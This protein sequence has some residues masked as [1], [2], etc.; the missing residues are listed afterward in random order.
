MTSDYL[1]YVTISTK[2]CN[3]LK[4]VS[5]ESALAEASRTILLVI[6][7]VSS[8]IT[9]VQHHMYIICMHIFYIYNFAFK[10]S[11]I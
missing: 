8:L 3:K 2:I 10:P 9:F 6:Y 11:Y 1:I 7:C 5:D 4:T